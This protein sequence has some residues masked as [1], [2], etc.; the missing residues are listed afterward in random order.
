MNLAERYRTTI[1]ELT[2]GRVGGPEL[3]DVLSRGR[4]KRRTR[5]TLVTGG[6]LAALTVAGLGGAWL[7]RPHVVVVV[8]PGAASSPSYRDFVP[9]TDVDETIQAAVADHVAGVPEADKV[10]P[11]DW[12]HD[13][14][15]PDS[16]AQ[17]ATDW[18]A[19]YS[20]GADE[21]LTVALFK[22]IPGEAA[23]TGCHPSMDAPGLP[24]T[25][26]TQ[27]DGSVLLSYGI[28]LGS[29]Y[30][31]AT[32]RVAAD[33]SSVEAFDDVRADS[34]AQAE[35]RASVPQGQLD[36][37]V[38]DATMTFPDPVVTPPPPDGS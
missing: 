16:Q 14:A 26:T 7:Q 2:D 31:F 35:N 21:N 12:N 9:G 10:Y 24:C 13:T 28:D 38:N 34:W 5:R 27:D 25:A 36:A 17:N 30:R 11:S 33:G 23:P 6:A 37:L 18:E 20:L 19:R 15:L 8:D 32:V 1:D 29:D 4:R 22:R 3:A